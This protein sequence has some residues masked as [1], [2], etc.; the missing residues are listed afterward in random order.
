[1]SLDALRELRRSH[2]KPDSL[3]KV[4]VGKRAP[5]FDTRPEVISVVEADQP[6]LMDWRPVLGLPLALFVCQGAEALAV[7]VAEAAVAAGAHLQGSAWH[8]SE[9]CTDEAI[10]PVLRQMWEVLCL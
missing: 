3:L 8:D 7:P 9:T 5:D 4:I 1:M 6:A 10:K 2:A